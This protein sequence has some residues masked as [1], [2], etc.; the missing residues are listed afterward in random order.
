MCSVC[1]YVCVCVCVCRP[2]DNLRCYSLDDINLV[3]ETGSLTRTW[4]SLI[5]LGRLGSKPQKDT[6]LCLHR[7]G[8]ISM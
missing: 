5:S 1:V 8:I 4:V 7:V 2:E 3:S 6:C